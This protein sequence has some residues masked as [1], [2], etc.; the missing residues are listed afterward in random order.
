MGS[1]Q[2]FKD[3]IAK[4]VFGMTKDEALEQQKCIHCKDIVDPSQWAEIDQREFQISGLC[5][6]C[7]NEITGDSD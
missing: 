2:E 3:A 1:L 4:D 7:W 6:K 5:P